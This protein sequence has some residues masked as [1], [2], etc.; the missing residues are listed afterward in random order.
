[1][2]SQIVGILGVIAAVL[3]AGLS[4]FSST[5]IEPNEWRLEYRHPNKTPF[6]EDNPYSEAKAALGRS[7][8]F[9]P[10]LSGSRLRSCASCHN[11]SLSWGDG[12]A[13]A[14]GDGQMSRR[15]PTALNLAWVTRT[16]W[17]GKF[18]DVEAFTFGPITSPL[19]MNAPEATVIERLMSI[20]GYVHLFSAAFGEGPITRAKIELSLATFERSIVSTT[21]PFDRWVMGDE[22]AIDHAAKRGF[23]LFNGRARCSECHSGWAFTDGSFHDI[24]TAEGDDVGRGRLFPTS[25]KLRYAFKTPTLRDVAR[26]APYM[27]DGSVPTL[28]EVIALYDRG[29]IERPSRSELIA[30][31]RLTQ[32]EKADLVAFLKTLTGEPEPTSLPVLPR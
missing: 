26:R 3:T 15:T 13:R 32:A 2:N 28:E 8:F 9:D 11:P 30:P 21:A 24:G 1:M 25:V 22:A 4:A 18:R 6:P 14:I 29:G 20:P 31:L 7:L 5:P 27:H 10:I 23:A 16:G 17:D 12:R 19:N